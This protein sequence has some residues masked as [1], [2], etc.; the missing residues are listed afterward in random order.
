MMLGAALPD[1]GFWLIYSMCI[2]LRHF[3]PFILRFLLIISWGL[4]LTPP[5]LAQETMALAMA[6]AIAR[7]MEV[8]G[9]NNS[10][11]TPPLG[12]GAPLPL[13][14]FPSAFNV[15]PN[16]T[17]VMPTPLTA[18]SSGSGGMPIQ[19]LLEQFNQVWSNGGRGLVNTT[20]TT[21][22]EGIWEDNQG[23]L[24]IVQR[25]RY[26]IYSPGNG[27]ID[28]DILLN[29]E[30]I[31]LTNRRENFTQSFEFALAQGRLVLRNH[32]GDVFLYR[33]LILDEQK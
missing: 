17:H 15:L 6:N 3:I 27:V 22:L 29:D 16:M 23:G 4:S 2:A 18:S 26:R 21:A 20:R 14:G 12:M 33:L 5:A 1:T 7:M 31:A 9:F 30:R 8:M 19:Q 28:G 32:N 10:N 25:N 24:L 11:I 13:A